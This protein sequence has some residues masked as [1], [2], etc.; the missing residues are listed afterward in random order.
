M[1]YSRSLSR[2]FQN[3]NS[4]VVSTRGKIALESGTSTLIE[5]GTDTTARIS[6]A[7]DSV[8]IATL[9]RKIGSGAGTTVDDAAEDIEIVTVEVSSVIGVGVY[10][11]LC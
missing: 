9:A 8:N 5:R 3:Q 6:I 2:R 10:G 7:E 11:G 1:M 4:S